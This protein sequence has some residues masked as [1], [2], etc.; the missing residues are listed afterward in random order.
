MMNPVD[1]DTDDDLMID[2]YE[3]IYSK[4][5]GLNASDSSDALL[6]IDQDG[7]VDIYFQRDENNACCLLDLKNK[8]CT[9]HNSRAFVCRS[10]FCIP[11]SA[12]F[13]DFRE[14]IVNGGENELI[15]L[16]LAEEANGAPPLGS[17]KL[18][19][20]LSHLDYPPNCQS[21]KKTYK[22]IILKNCINKSY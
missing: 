16:L 6:D 21:D 5:P 1:N 10:H 11:R 20:L 8:C 14:E 13:E 12:V 9:Q 18:S 7:L 19:Q 2:G 22:E 4:N 17:K 15:R 3:F